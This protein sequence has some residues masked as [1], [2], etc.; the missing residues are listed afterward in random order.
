MSHNNNR[1]R[2][3]N[4]GGGG[5]KHQQAVV[6]DESNPILMAFQGFARELDDKHDRYERIVKIGRDITI[7]SKRIIFLLHTIDHRKDNAE[8]VL[9][10]A[11]QRLQKVCTGSFAEIAKELSGRDQYQYAR[12]FSPGLQEFIEAYTFFEYSSGENLSDWE[13]V[14]ER[15]KYN[16]EEK[17]IECLVQ[18]IE[19]MLGIADMTGEVMR[20]CVNSLGSGDV[21]GCFNANRFLQ[22][23]FTGYIG[24]GATHNR[25]MSRKMHTLRQSIMKTEAVCYNLKVRGKEAAKWGAEENLF[26]D[27]AGDHQANNAA[28]IDEGFFC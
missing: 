11:H 14:Q 1:R 3:N 4:R 26:L 23:L 21:D 2:H 19:F 9:A 6:V 8:K 27:K 28:D 20:R 12:A 15:L 7:E 24:L 25:E 5:G 17:S 13:V 10:E 22:T 18:P 16:V